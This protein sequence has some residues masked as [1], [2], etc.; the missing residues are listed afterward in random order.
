MTKKLQNFL[1]QQQWNSLADF[2]VPNFYFSWKISNL[3]RTMDLNF[4]KV[5]PHVSLWLKRFLNKNQIK[6]IFLLAT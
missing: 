5:L 4:S 2:K 3:F 1:L 6:D